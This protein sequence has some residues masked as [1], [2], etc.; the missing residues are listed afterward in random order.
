MLDNKTDW[1]VT[2]VREEVIRRMA[3]NYINEA[4]ECGDDLEIILFEADRAM[5]RREGERKWYV[6]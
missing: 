3:D 4:I 5:E 1:F 2:A 6:R